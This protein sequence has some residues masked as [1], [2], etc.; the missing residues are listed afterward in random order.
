MRY[1][2]LFLMAV[3]ASAQL[4]PRVSIS[5]SF[6]SLAQVNAARSVIS[7]KLFSVKSGQ[8]H[9]L[10]N[11]FTV[12]TNA[13]MVTINRLDFYVSTNLQNQALRW[14]V[15]NQFGGS[16]WTLIVGSHLCPGT[17][18]PPANWLGCALDPRAQS[19]NIVIVP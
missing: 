16:G 6:T 2:I 1:L 15:T 11:A 5:G 19:T 3:D 18:P 7:N 10:D 17:N 13:G 8:I 14:L 4:S 12:G 9:S